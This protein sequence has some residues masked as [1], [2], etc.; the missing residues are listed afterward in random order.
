MDCVA[1]SLFSDEVFADLIVEW[2]KKD[3][4]PGS[5]SSSSSS[6]SASAS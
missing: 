2:L 4:A 3:P 6:V 1:G 5:S